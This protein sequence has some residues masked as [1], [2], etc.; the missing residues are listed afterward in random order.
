MKYHNGMMFS[1]KD[2]DNDINQNSCAQ[3]YKGAWWF[4]RCHSSNLNGKY[5]G[6]QHSN[7][8]NGII[9]NTWTGGFYSLKSTRMMIKRH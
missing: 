8:A 7:F 1:T 3:I 5:L 9:W 4:T 2:K 6:G